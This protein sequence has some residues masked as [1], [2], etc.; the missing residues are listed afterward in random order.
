LEDLRQVFLT[1]LND[2]AIH[3]VKEAPSGK[4]FAKALGRQLMEAGLTVEIAKLYDG[5]IFEIEIV[6]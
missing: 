2:E 3:Q 6:E 5:R 4:L 1:D